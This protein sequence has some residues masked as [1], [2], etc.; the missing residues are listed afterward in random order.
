MQLTGLQLAQII[1]TVVKL[2]FRQSIDNALC[3][4][5]VQPVTLLRHQS[6]NPI[7]FV[8]VYLAHVTLSAGP[9]MHA[10]AILNV[11]HIVTDK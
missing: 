11:V 4:N 9:G 6:P 3:E 10:E 7:P 5:A 8:E 1:P 2:D